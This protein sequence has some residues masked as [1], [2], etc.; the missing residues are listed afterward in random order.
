MHRP[1]L[2]LVTSPQGFPSTFPFSVQDLKDFRANPIPTKSPSL[3]KAFISPDFAWFRSS[4]RLESSLSMC[5][6]SAPAG[7]LFTQFYELFVHHQPV[8]QPWDLAQETDTDFS[9][10]RFKR[11]YHLGFLVICE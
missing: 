3:L 9:C 5:F 1:V 4:T 11:L 2:A 7:A 8:L 10:A 6:A